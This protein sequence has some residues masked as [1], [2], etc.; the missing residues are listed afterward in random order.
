VTDLGFP[1]FLTHDSTT[2]T[3]ATSF[4]K[5]VADDHRPRGPRYPRITGAGL[6][7]DWWGDDPDAWDRVLL[8]DVALP[9]ICEVDAAEVERKVDSTSPTGSDGGTVRDKGYGLA[10]F[11]VK[12]RI[13]TREQ[14][15][16][17][18]RLGPLLDPRR[19]GRERQ[20]TRIEHPELL[21]IG[22]TQAYITGVT[23]LKA[24]QPRGSREATISFI[25]Y[26]P[27]T[28][29]ARSVTRT[30]ATTAGGGGATAFETGITNGK[31][32][33]NEPETTPADDNADP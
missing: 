24:S 29:P 16:F 23:S 5:A 18:V 26:A 33:A 1:S 9:G 14:F 25:E 21:L 20:P 11:K 4:H 31:A 10:K 22:I 17:W 28:A 8:D 3:A 27:A 7:V 2:G 32:A 12:V 6:P 15:Q 19:R 30:A 13:W